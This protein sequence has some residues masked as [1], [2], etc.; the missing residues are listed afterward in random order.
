MAEDTLRLYEIIYAIAASNGRESAVFGDC[1]P[2][3]CEAFARSLACD[4]FPELW[5]EIPLLGEPWFDFHALTSRSDLTASSSFTFETTGGFPEVFEWF[6]AQGE[7]V[8][9]LA[10]SWDTG[11]GDAS[12]P[13]V[14]LLLYKEDYGLACDFLKAAGRA[15]AVPAYR[16]FTERIPN[17]WFACYS[18]VFPAR[19]GHNL[20]V[21]CIPNRDLQIAYAKDPSLLRDHLHK[22]GLSNIGGSI[23]ERC[24]LL[25]SA[26]FQLEFQFDIDEDGLPEPMFAA[27]ARFS[28]PPGEDSYHCFD[29]E[30]AAG[31]MMKQ[32]EAWGLVDERWRL[33]ADMM[34][35]MK[36]T[37]ENISRTIYCYPAF[38]KLRWKDG[39][40]FDAKSYLIAGCQHIDAP[41]P[42]A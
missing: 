8:R 34:F 17:S 25:A 6:A 4:A 3:A 42:D 23:V 20:R 37:K 21:E 1:A 12:S 15:D 14:Q 38:I 36:V 22:V 29:P 19:P 32:L 24:R 41:T 9:Q 26:P 2:L 11:S 39:E 13:A 30:G 18:G 40:P 35:A 31:T 33:L 10:L 27:S 16:A 5:F 28:D 7:G